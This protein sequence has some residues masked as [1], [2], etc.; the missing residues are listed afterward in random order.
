MS[1]FDV[2]SLLD[3]IYASSPN[4]E[5][6]PLIG[7]TG[8]F[9]D[10]EAR[11]CDRYYK[12]VT[13]A[14][15]TPVIIPPLSD[16]ATLI[17]TLDKIDGLILSGGADFNPLWAGEEPAEG[18]HGINPE[19]DEAELLITTLAYNRNI[20]MLGVCRG[21]QT[22]AMALGGK[23]CQD[24]GKGTNRIKHSQEAGRKGEP[25]HS[26]E[27]AEGSMLHDL[28]AQRKIFVNSFHHQ[29]VECTGCR[30]KVTATA[31]DNVIEAIEST[32]QRPIMG[33]Q[34]HPEW[35]DDGLPL[36]RWL[37]DN[38]RIYN[39]AKALHHKI[40]TLDSHCD[41]PMFFPQGVDFGKHDSRILVDIH[42]MSDGRQDAVVMAA[43]LPQPKEGQKFSD[44]AP[45]NAE[46]PTAYAN[47]IFDK[48]EEMVAL[49]SHSVAIARSVSDLKAN[50]ARGL[51]S[52]MLAIENG[53]A[54]GGDISN[55]EKFAQRGVSYITLCH[56]GDNELCDSARG[57]NRWQGLSQLG[58]DV[59]R[60]MNRHGVMVDLSHAAESSFY[61][62]LEVSS[63]PIVCSHSNCRSLC[64]HPRNITDSQ[65][66]ALAT[67][68]GVMQV[69]L[70]DGFLRTTASEASVLDALSHLDHAIKVMGIDHVGIGSDFDGDGGVPGF[71][72]SDDAL[73]F[74]MHLL[75]RKYSAADIEKIWGGN[76]LRVLEQHNRA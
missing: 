64:D 71:A 51:K 48:I 55:V 58:I 19:R 49:S 45:L 1:L 74:T 66:R 27:I 11:L 18:L 16:K 46:T 8:N 33:V 59:I 2:Q 43:Y 10:G 3:D 60:E 29:A 70:Y 7:I 20:P 73:A 37:V 6:R 9:A 35:M 52:V 50:K 26:V 28:Y 39:D 44:I 32:E 72:S 56:N 68:G 38:A 12:Q 54:L 47:I 76:W 14:G 65:M 17:N 42:K 24:I 62:A 5:S 21:I 15:G 36:F 61:G 67:K 25:T 53:I 75:R 30:F 34:W 57:E 22:I 69:T 40:I 63:L 23:V 31:A 4:A 13:A 41:T